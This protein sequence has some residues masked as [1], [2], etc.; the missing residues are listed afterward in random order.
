MKRSNDEMKINMNIN[1][2]EKANLTYMN[3]LHQ[4]FCL[5]NQYKIKMNIKTID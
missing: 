2:T 1:S 3:E 5:T 4:I